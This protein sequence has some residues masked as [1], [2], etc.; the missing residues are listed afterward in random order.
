MQPGQD[1][2][3]SGMRIFTTLDL[4][5]Q[6]L[7]Q[8]I[9]REQVQTLRPVYDLSNAALVALKPGTAIIGAQASGADSM[10]RSLF[11]GEA[12]ALPGPPGRTKRVRQ[13]S[14][15]AATGWW[16]RK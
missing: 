11:A 9:V 3:R 4:P 8:Q 7:A 12:T 15:G 2:R 10:R 5:M 1:V 6:T 13:P 14:A 16:M